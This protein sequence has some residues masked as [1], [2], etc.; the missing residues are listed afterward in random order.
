MR[1][2]LPR[3]EQPCRRTRLLSTPVWTMFCVAVLCHHAA[4]E[5]QGRIAVSSGRTIFY[6]ERGEGLPLLLIHGGLGLD[7]SYFQPWLDPLSRKLRLV[8]LDLR[9][10]GRSAPILLKNSRLRSAPWADS[11]ALRERRLSR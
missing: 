7:H 4:A 2:H 1:G 11:V 6:Q 3:A 8:Y 5:R 9:A 10:N